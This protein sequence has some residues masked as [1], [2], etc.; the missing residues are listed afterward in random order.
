MLE[1]GEFGKR[2]GCWRGRIAFLAVPE[3]SQRPNHD[4]N[5]VFRVK[6]PRRAANAGFQSGKR[7]PEGREGD[8]MRGMDES[9][10][11]KRR[12]FQI[13]LS[14]VVVITCAVAVIM[15]LN[16]R[17]FN[18][19]SGSVVVIGELGITEFQHSDGA[20]YGMPYN[21]INIGSESR[22]TPDEQPIETHRVGQFDFF[23]FFVD[24][25]AWA[26][27][28]VAVALVSESLIRRREGRKPPAPP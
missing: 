28:L 9:K 23:H 1:E 27:M 14:T 11:P 26:G 18:S 3:R 13:H 21:F 22:L 25:I 7:W 16:F 20:E 5:A 12:W 2:G 15:G 10:K 19:Y 6:S 17:K 4:W 8:R 24:V